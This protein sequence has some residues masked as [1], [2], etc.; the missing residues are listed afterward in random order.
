[1][2][3]CRNASLRVLPTLRHRVY[4]TASRAMAGLANSTSDDEFYSRKLELQNLQGF[5]TEGLLWKAT[6]ADATAR[7]LS[8]DAYLYMVEKH[9]EEF[10]D[11]GELFNRTYFMQELRS[12]LTHPGSFVL[13]LGGKNVGKMQVVQALKME[14]G[15]P[16]GATHCMQSCFALS[17]T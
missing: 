8:T 9:M 16:K 14:L 17:H 12:S 3:F 6:Q 4:S 15:G 13:L 1:M 7:T 2:M 11:D 10:L 5:T